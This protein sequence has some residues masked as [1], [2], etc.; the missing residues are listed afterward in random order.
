MYV[1]IILK[2]NQKLGITLDTSISKKCVVKSVKADSIAQKAGV[3]KGWDVST[4][5]G[6]NINSV[7]AF[8]SAL[9]TAPKKSKECKITFSKQNPRKNIVQEVK[10]EVKIF[11]SINFYCVRVCGALFSQ[12]L[13]HASGCSHLAYR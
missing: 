3:E 6:S 1:T 12:N 13:T 7:Q 2:E 5:D 11:C 4:I 9:R 8:K 10:D